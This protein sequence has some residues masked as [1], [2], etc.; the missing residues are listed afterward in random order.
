LTVTEARSRPIPPG[1]QQ[2]TRILCCGRVEQRFAFTLF[3]H[4]T[5]A[6]HHQLMTQRAHHLQIVTDKQIRQLMLLL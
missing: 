6:Q 1:G 2:L 4:F 5:L 3:H